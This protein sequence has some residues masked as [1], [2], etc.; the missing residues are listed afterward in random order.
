MKLLPQEHATLIKQAIQSAQTKGDFPPFDLPEVVIQPSKKAGQGDYSTPIAMSLTKLTGM[1]PRDIAE[2][3]VRHLPNADFVAQVEIA[4]AGFINFTLSKAFLQAQVDA[5]IAE[6]EHLFTLTIGN[7]KRVQVEFV[8]ANPTGPITIGH[9]RG[10]VVGDAMARLYEAG[11][12]DVQREYYFNNGGNQ[13]VLMGKSLQARYL[14]QLGLPFE[15][16]EG[17]YKGEYI[18]DYAKKLVDEQG[19]TLKNADWTAF[20]MYAETQMFDWIKSTLDRVDIRHD[21][22]FNEYSLYE[23]RALWNVLDE[24]RERGYIYEASEWEGASEEKKALAQE[25]PP[26]TW[27]RTAQFGDDSDRVMVKSDGSPTYTLPDIAYHRNKIERG[28]DILINVLGA[29]HLHQAKVVSWGLQ[30][31]GLPAERLHVI[32]IQMV[33]TMRDG[34]EFKISKRAGIFDTLDDLID[35]TSADAIRYHMLARSPNSHVTFDVDKVVE[36]TN[37]NPVY[38]IQNAHVRCAGILREAEARG[39]SDEG[40]DLSL[41]GEDELAFTRKV[42][43]LGDVIQECLTSYE[44]HKIATFA[45]ELASLF[46]PLYD[47]VRVLHTEVPEPVGKARLRFYRSAQVAFYRVLRLMG[48][49]APDR[50]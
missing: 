15:F 14:E 7:G 18:T 35:M 31:L 1:K 26:A 2:T 43:E 16:P 36:K 27:F 24:L 32:F 4:G 33:K 21:A 12:Y 44:P 46:H 10:A 8:S 25:K 37:E 20:K 13:M 40:A 28:F 3:I 9:T 38:Y 45:Y 22:F 30:A 34:Q 39:L 41:L 11:G 42:L 17:G 29:D 5:I 19:D 47:R 23:T 49:S 50:M 6:G 48:M